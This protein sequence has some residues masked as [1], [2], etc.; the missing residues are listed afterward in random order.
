MSA[1]LSFLA[2]DW[3]WLYT[4]HG[5]S[6]PLRV[7]WH[8]TIKCFIMGV[9]NSI[10]NIGCVKLSTEAVDACNEYTM[11]SFLHMNR[12][13]IQLNNARIMKYVTIV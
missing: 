13:A 8:L 3:W 6:G 11:K 7:G 12:N 5:E 9:T 1:T 2:V 4:K 10:E